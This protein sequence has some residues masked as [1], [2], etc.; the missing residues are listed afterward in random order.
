MSGITWEDIIAVQPALHDLYV[1]ALSVVDDRSKPFFCG[2]HVWYKQGYRR[3]LTQLVGYGADP[4]LPSFIRSP[5]AYAIAY[6]KVYDAIPGCRG[7]CGC[8]CW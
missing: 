1:A 6:Q 8:W 3:R 2:H 7:D 4:L 5:E